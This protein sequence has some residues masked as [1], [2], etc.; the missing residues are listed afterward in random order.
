[1][2]INLTFLQQWIGKSETV[3]DTVTLAPMNALSAALDHDSQAFA[4]GAALPPVWHWL[5]FLPVHR[6]SLVGPDG[7]PKRGGFLPPVELPRRMW[8]GSQLLFS[9]RLQAGDNITRLS[10]IEDVT[11]KN[12][13]SGD[14]VFVKVLHEISDA[15]GVAITER[16]DIVYRDH[17]AASEA[18]PIP[19]P[20]P[21]SAQWKREIHPD[22]VLLFR[23]SALT[24]NGHRIHY[25]RTYAV[26]QE[27]YS[28]LVV[29]G[30][31]LATLLLDLLHREMPEAT[32]K[33]YSFRAVSP[34]ID[35]APFFVCGQ[36]DGD[37][38]KTVWL[39]IAGN[40]GTLRMEANAVLA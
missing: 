28:G 29:H 39:W 31:L 26:E 11:Y 5:Y 30:P 25:D 40:D 14:L 23:Y 19:R 18:L 13:R 27:R 21:E 16:Q 36:T 1:M 9:R 4:Q 2:P 35:T 7:H 15:S 33:A 24:L 12:G 20:A 22:P 17:P 3:L 6:Q 38:G 10:T 37:Q 8:A 32:V 34:V